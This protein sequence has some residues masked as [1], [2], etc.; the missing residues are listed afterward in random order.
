VNFIYVKE[1]GLLLSCAE[2]GLWCQAWTK[3]QLCLSITFPSATVRGPWGLCKIL[4]R[5]GRG[6]QLSSWAGPEEG[7]EK[8]NSPSTHRCASVPRAGGRVKR[9]TWGNCWSVNWANLKFQ[10]RHWFI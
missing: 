6:E 2:L 5:V 1:C 10:C 8:G 7:W 4:V 9:A 3:A